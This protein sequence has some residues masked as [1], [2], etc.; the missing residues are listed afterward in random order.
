MIKRL[1]DIIASFIG[2]IFLL[3]LFFLIALWIKI[4]SEGPI[5]YR[6]QRVGQKGNFFKIHKFRTMKQFSEDRRKLTVGEDSRITQCGRILRKFKFDELP[7]LIDVFIGNMSLV[8]PRPEVQEF[9]DIYPVA[10]RNKIL[11]IKPG[12]TDMASIAM[13]SEND[14]LGKYENPHQAYIEHILPIKQKYYLNYVDNHSIWGDIK[15]IFLTFKK[16]ITQ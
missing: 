10:M 7:Q 8:G 13:A 2:L 4:D 6:Q 9:M 5:F 11:S 14:I 12:I 1:F 3:P 16:I 15:I